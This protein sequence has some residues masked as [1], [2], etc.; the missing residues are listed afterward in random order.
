VALRAAVRWPPLR[1]VQACPCHGAPRN[2]GEGYF[3]GLRN[4]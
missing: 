1:D 4:R 2:P 3:A